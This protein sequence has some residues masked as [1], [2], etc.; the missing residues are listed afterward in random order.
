VRETRGGAT[1]IS[2]DVLS[3]FA[4]FYAGQGHPSQEPYKGRLFEYCRRTYVGH[5]WSERRRL[6]LSPRGLRELIEA[7]WNG[8]Q[9]QRFRE[10]LD[11]VCASWKDWLYAMQQCRCRRRR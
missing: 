3:L 7:K 10:L 9:D 2:D 1:E 6:S 11:L 5:H 8:P 4:G